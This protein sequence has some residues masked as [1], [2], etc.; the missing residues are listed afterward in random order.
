MSINSPDVNVGRQAEVATCPRD[1]RAR[2]TAICHNVHVARTRDL[3]RGIFDN[4]N[5]Y[6]ISTIRY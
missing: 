4:K 1:Y 5:K 3:Y 2:W 6:Y